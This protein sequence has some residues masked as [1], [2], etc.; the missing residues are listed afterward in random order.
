MDQLSS[1][2]NIKELTRVQELVYELRIEQV[3]TRNVITVT[4]NQTIAE[5]K[6]VLRVNRISGCPVV[7]NGVL[8]GM[9]SLENLIRALEN[10]ELDAPIR[11]KMTSSVV[12]VR[13]DESVVSAVNL[14]ARLGYGRFPVLDKDGNLVGIITQGDI[15]RGLLKQMEVQWH[16][17][18]IKRYRASHIFE[19]IE[20][21][22]T[23]LIL[24][25]SVKAHDFVHG[26]EAS[27]KI[28]RALERLGAHPRIIRRVAVATY[29]AETNVMI[30]SYGGEIIAEVRPERMRV[31][32][33]DTGPGIP[34]IEQALQ[35]GFSTAPDWIR[36]LGF[37]AGMGL[38]NIQACAD[39]MKLEST[40]GVGTRL[41]MI[42][43]LK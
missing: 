1:A 34:D 16:A 41:E 26:G 2:S 37:G 25:Y 39:E 23:A 8:V 21:D 19:D 10:G 36:E 38:T 24:R 7:E 20:S 18:E 9:I 11:H 17:E 42:F 13:A 30:H 29:E 33:V 28:K 43:K 15:V 27:S 14:F 5:L 35:P 3:M 4:P 12:S 40:V 32:A 31:T 22:Q 6:E